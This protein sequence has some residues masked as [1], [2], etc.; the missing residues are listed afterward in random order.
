MAQQGKVKWFSEKKGFGFITPE[1]NP[2][3][4]DVFVHFSGI[5]QASGFKTLLEGEPVE[6]DVEESPKGPGAVN[7]KRL[8]PR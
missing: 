8:D 7:V 4:K 1:G 3:P 2:T 5:V 6:F